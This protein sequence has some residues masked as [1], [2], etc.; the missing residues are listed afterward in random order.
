MWSREFW[1]VLKKCL[2]NR[3]WLLFSW[4]C[5]WLILLSLASLHWYWLYCYLP[6]R[7]GLQTRHSLLL[8]VSPETFNKQVFFTLRKQQRENGRGVKWKNR[9]NQF[10]P[11]MLEN[12]T[13]ANSAEKKSLKP[14]KVRE[15]LCSFKHTF[16]HFLY[17][18]L[19]PSE[20]FC[21]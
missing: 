15:L 9:Q 4:L 3:D 7:A 19:L 12:D 6:L 11:A 10:D 14:A 8:T 16:L 21:W 17:F 1:F 2:W 20:S 18:I 13:D 5:C